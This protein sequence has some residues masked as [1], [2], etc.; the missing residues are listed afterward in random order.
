MKYKLLQFKYFIKSILEKSPVISDIVRESFFTKFP[1]FFPHDNEFIGARY[2]F[3]EKKINICDIGANV[4]LASLTFY[5]MGFEKCRYFLF[6]PN[7]TL[8]KK[9]KINTTKIKNIFYSKFGLSDKEKKLFFYI[10]FY[11]NLSMHCNGS[12]DLK[13]LRL[14]LKKTY[15]INILKK[16]KIKKFKFNTLP[17]DKLKKKYRVDLV[18]ID[19]EG[20]EIKVIK[21][22]K[23]TIHK[24]NPVILMEYNCNLFENIAKTSVLK[25]YMFKF[26]DYRKNKFLTCNPKKK[27]NYRNIYAIPKNNYP[28]YSIS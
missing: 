25:N 15:K 4:G 12:F 7:I 9:L 22:M 13:N 28:D 14:Y 1:I 8:F 5:Y 3:K 11:E 23:K 21:G 19:V 6:E 27:Y 24:Y 18:K 26:F 20:H 10:P 17:F 16:I 2:L